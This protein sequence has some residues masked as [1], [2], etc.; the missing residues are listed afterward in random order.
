M[1][2]TK[3]FFRLMVILVVLLLWTTLQLPSH[4]QT[5][6]TPSVEIS[7][8]WPAL[9]YSAAWSPNGDLILV[10]TIGGEW[11]TA[12]VY[13]TADGS[14]VASIPVPAD[15]LSGGDWE[16][17]ETLYLKRYSY[18]TDETQRLVY[19][20]ADA[21]YLETR[22]D[23]VKPFPIVDYLNDPFIRWEHTQTAVRMASNP[24]II[25]GVLQV[26]YDPRTDMDILTVEVTDRTGPF[27][28]PTD[29]AWTSD[30]GRIVLQRGLYDTPT[31]NLIFRLGDSDEST[32][33]RAEWLQDDR[34]LLVS[35]TDDV[36]E[37]WDTETQ[38]RFTFESVVGQLDF[39]LSPDET[40][41]AVAY[42]WGA[43]I[44][45]G[46]TTG[47]RLYKLPHLNYIAVGGGA[48]E[49][50]VWSPDST[51]LATFIANDAVYFLRYDQP[52]A[53]GSWL[54]DEAELSLYPTPSTADTPLI[55]LPIGT[56][57]TLIGEPLKTEEGRWWLVEGEGVQG[58]ALA[59]DEP[60]YQD[61]LTRPRNQVDEFNATLTLWTLR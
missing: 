28:I 32:I 47:E 42:D 60:T 33:M 41:L 46:M 58:Y 43:V 27:G 53:V 56:P 30:G 29:P 36:I 44:V 10:I 37:L 9:R 48:F 51:H 16:D 52:A 38:T 45:Y 15:G 18:E 49:L 59:Y 50:P 6:D 13:R 40:M 17:N 14:L 21:Q 39:T 7:I 11:D 12:I 23:P 3:Q 2:G 19:R 1:L 31:G 26:L 61:Y 24:D 35:R 22:D 25:E 55:T 34:H 57:I 54:G 5:P 8:P 20:A 4:A